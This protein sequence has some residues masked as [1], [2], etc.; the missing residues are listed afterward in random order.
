MAEAAKETVAGTGKDAFNQQ[1]SNLAVAK[2]VVE[3]VFES[4]WDENGVRCVGGGRLDM[5]HRILGLFT[6]QIGNSINGRD[7]KANMDC[8]DVEKVAKLT[9]T[10]DTSL[11]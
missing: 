10:T 5:I 9:P 2:A 11:L 6:N 8:C 7:P 3:T 4:T 1:K